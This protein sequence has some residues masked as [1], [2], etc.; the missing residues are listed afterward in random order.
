[1][2]AGS[3]PAEE[4]RFNNV[5]RTEPGGAGLWVRNRCESI[6]RCFAASVG[7]AESVIVR[8]LGLDAEPLGLNSAALLGR[9]G[10]QSDRPIGK[11]AD[12]ECE[13]ATVVSQRQH[14]AIKP[15]RRVTS[16]VRWQRRK[17]FGRVTK[18]QPAQFIRGIESERV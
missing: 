18:L 17:P 12:S 13:H 2:A 10:P 4:F 11:P 16:I 14:T 9:L 6:E 8:A 1:V 15:E 3:K 5:E 7:G